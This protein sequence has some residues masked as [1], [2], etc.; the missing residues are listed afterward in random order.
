MRPFTSY[1]VRRDTFDDAVSEAQ[2][3]GVKKS[4]FLAMLLR[5]WRKLSK[6]QQLES[7][8]AEPESNLPSSVGESVATRGVTAGAA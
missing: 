3:V 5:G 8:P 2:R 1:A 4:D 7:I 6:R